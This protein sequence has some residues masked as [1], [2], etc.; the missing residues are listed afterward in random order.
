[1]KLLKQNELP[2]FENGPFSGTPDNSEDVHAQQI[3]IVF[4]ALGAYNGYYKYRYF[5]DK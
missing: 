5:S 3:H 1:M 2:Y 4:S